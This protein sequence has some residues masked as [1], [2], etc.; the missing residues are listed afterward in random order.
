MPDEITTTTPNPDYKLVPVK[1]PVDPGAAIYANNL[2][3]QFDGTAIFLT[4]AQVNPP[5]A[6]GKDEGETKGLQDSITSVIATPVVRLVIPLSNFRVMLA[7]IQQNM[8]KI[9]KMVK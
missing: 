4:Y 8:D 7:M 5:L 1:W 6:V 9:E 3:V 2:C